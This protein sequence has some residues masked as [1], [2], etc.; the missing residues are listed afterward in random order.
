[1]ESVAWNSDTTPARNRVGWFRFHAGQLSAGQG[2]ARK[3]IHFTFSRLMWS[4]CGVER[5]RRGNSWRDHDTVTSCSGAS[6]GHQMRCHDSGQEPWELH[7]QW[8]RVL[9]DWLPFV[10]KFDLAMI[11]SDAGDSLSL[12]LGIPII[13][14]RGGER[15][16]LPRAPCSPL[17]YYH[18]RSLP[19]A[20]P[21]E[22]K[23]FQQ[24]NCNWAIEHWVDWNN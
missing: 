9:L 12:S 24:P 4:E 2:P 16:R 3:G 20:Q 5:R 7:D 15:E 8:V 22:S 6:G 1:M 14:R 19:W 11:W 23:S 18:P 17:Q 13:L 21:T 10:T